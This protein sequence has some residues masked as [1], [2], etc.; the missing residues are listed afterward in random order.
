VADIAFR[1]SGAPVLGLRDGS[2]GSGGDLLPVVRG[3]D[4]WRVTIDHEHYVDRTTID[5]AVTGGLAPLPML[6]GMV[7]LAVGVKGTLNAGALWYDNATGAITDQR[8]VDAGKRRRYCDAAGKCK[9]LSDYEIL[10]DIEPLCPVVPPTATALPTPTSSPT[11]TGTPTATPSPTNTA[12]P[13][14]SVTVTPSPTVTPTA[15][16]RPVY[17][18]LL[19]RESCAER[20]VHTDVALVIDTSTSM[21]NPTRDGRPKLDAV[22]DAARAF[23]ALMDFAPEGGYDQVAV[24]AFNDR[25]WVAESLGSDADRLRAAIDRLPD[26]VAQGTRLDL[27]IDIGRSALDVPTRIAANTAVIILLTDG[28]PNRVP[29]GPGGTQEETVLAAADRAK[30]T[31]ALIYTIGVGQPDAVDPADRINAD[32]LRAIAS[33]PTMFYQTVDAAELARIYAEIAYTLG[34]PPDSFWGRRP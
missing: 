21:R 18:P 26:S 12:T 32:L 13:K 2:V 6:D 24:A 17:L 7:T 29:L 22:Q 30:A 10:G 4:G 33:T 5:E 25:A 16:P 27:A 8:I 20:K 3:R 15:I 11:P 28:L 19:L 14:P 9:M 23:V 1:V 31:G 34:C